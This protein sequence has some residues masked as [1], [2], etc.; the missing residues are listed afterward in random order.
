MGQKK[1]KKIQ[2]ESLSLL[3]CTIKKKTHKNLKYIKHTFPN[4]VKWL[5]ENTN[6]NVMFASKQVATF[7]TLPSC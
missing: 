3:K 2:D 4:S 6:F 5:R 1:Q 7:R